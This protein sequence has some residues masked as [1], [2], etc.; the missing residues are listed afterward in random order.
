MHLFIAISIVKKKNLVLN[1]V[2]LP[3]LFGY[4]KFMKFDR[5][6]LISKHFFRP[7]NFVELFLILKLFKT[8]IKLFCKKFFDNCFIVFHSK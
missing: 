3:K 7:I 1:K 8:E 6:I 4:Y 2:L 5:N